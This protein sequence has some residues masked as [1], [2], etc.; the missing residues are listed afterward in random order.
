MSRLISDPD[1]FVKF[2]EDN[3]QRELESGALSIELFW[4][5]LKQWSESTFGPRI[6]RGPLGPLKHLKKEVDEAIAAYD[7]MIREID[8]N[9]QDKH[10][11]QDMEA[12]AD[13]F[14]EEIADLQFLVFDIAQR[15]GMTYYNLRCTV[16]EKLVKNRSRSWGP[17]SATEAVEHIRDGETP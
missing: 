12:A 14:R 2:C 4:N 17:A 7:N 1:A 13:A 6:L 3:A 5:L 16:T 15:A 11:V 10:A 8:L 9:R